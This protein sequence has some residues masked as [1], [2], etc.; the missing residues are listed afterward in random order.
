MASELARYYAH[1]LRQRAR[2]VTHLPEGVMEQVQ[3]EAGQVIDEV[4]KQCR[5]EMKEQ[6][7]AL[8]PSDSP[9]WRVLDAIPL[10]T[11]EAKRY[12]EKRIQQ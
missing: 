5:R 12:V 11:R 4:I 9:E 10:N 1:E 2:K 3:R 7:L 6:V 8:V